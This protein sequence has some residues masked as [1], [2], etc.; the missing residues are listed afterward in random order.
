MTSSPVSIAPSTV[1]RPK[2]SGTICNAIIY[3]FPNVNL[4]FTRTQ[5]LSHSSLLL[6]AAH[7]IC[8]FQNVFR[9]TMPSALFKPIFTTN[10]RPHNRNYLLFLFSGTRPT[11]YIIIASTVL[12][13][14]LVYRSGQ[15]LMSGI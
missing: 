6:F 12:Y 14:A 7:T 10:C 1:R 11:H 8:Q 9:I 3:C 15:A 2:S 13:V 4:L 5:L